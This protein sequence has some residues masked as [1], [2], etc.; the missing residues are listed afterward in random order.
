MLGERKCMFRCFKHFYVQ[1]K[2]NNIKNVKTQ[3][4]CVLSL[5]LL[6]DSHNLNIVLVQVLLINDITLKIN[7]L[8]VYDTS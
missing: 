6:S 7:V 4:R 5:M 8:K 3:L 2:A 1:L